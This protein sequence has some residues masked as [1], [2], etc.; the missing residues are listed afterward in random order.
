MKIPVV[1]VAACT[2]CMGC[3]EVCSQ[4]FRLNEALGMIEVVELDHYSRE[5]VDEAIKY[6][7]EDAIQWD[8]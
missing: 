5:L 6:C 7:P 8:G 3:V 1:D 4:V 2:L